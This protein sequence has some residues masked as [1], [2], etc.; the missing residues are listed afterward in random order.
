MQKKVWSGDIQEKSCKFLTLIGNF[1][2]VIKIQQN[3]HAQ[4]LISCNN[5]KTNHA[6]NSKVE[7]NDNHS[8][9]SEMTQLHINHAM[10]QTRWHNN[11]SEETTHAKNIK[12]QMFPK[13]SGQ[14]RQHII[15][16]TL[17]SNLWPLQPIISAF[18]LLYNHL[19]VVLSLYSS[20]TN[21][22][23]LPTWI[24]KILL[25]LQVIKT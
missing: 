24:N 25:H 15:Q 12:G 16:M 5:K 9:L 22:V 13:W 6:V 4:K 3:N 20:L 21:Y 19:Y 11:L 7:W 10:T 2:K 17:T 23:T 1:T 14:H 8:K 18:Q